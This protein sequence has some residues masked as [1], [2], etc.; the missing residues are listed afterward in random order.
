MP[1]KCCENVERMQPVMRLI[2]FLIVIILREIELKLK[3]V[4][5]ETGASD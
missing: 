4:L 5:A 3:P 2:F 1:L